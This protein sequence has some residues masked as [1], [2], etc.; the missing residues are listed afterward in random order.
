MR[1]V[2]RAWATLQPRQMAIN[3]PEKKS[4][5]RA[6]SRVP[7]IVQRDLHPESDRGA[8]SENGRRS[9]RPKKRHPYLFSE[10]FLW[11]RLKSAYRTSRNSIDLLDYLAT[12][13]R[14][15]ERFYQRF[16]VITFAVKGDDCFFRCKIDLHVF[17]ARSLFERG[18]DPRLTTYRSG[19]AGNSKGKAR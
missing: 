13:S 12:K 19:H 18:L 1:Q 16:S 2:P 15:F 5:N 6:T 9:N 3:H 10:R 11:C 17:D 8:A 4:A 14:F 7:A